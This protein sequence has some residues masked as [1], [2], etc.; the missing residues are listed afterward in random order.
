MSLIYLCSQSYYML[1]IYIVYK[2]L[3]TN[4][5]YMKR[6]LIKYVLN[7]YLFY[8]LLQVANSSYEF[9]NIKVWW[10]STSL[11]NFCT[12]FIDRIMFLFCQITN[13]CV[14]QITKELY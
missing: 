10:F 5:L 9:A 4:F 8:M 6:N 12:K 13:L 14:C 2:I 3:L 1:Y 7:Y 11:S